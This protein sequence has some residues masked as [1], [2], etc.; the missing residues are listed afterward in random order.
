MDLVFLGTFII[1]AS[2]YSVATLFLTEKV[3]D[4]VKKILKVDVGAVFGYIIPAVVDFALLAGTKNF[5]VGFIFTLLIG[6][7]YTGPTPEVPATAS[8]FYFWAL[9]VVSYGM[10]GGLFDFL[11]KLAKYIAD[12]RA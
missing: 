4:L 8:S 5:G 10:A 9:L 12:R 1:T 11:K 6:Q 2:A 7:G 3:K